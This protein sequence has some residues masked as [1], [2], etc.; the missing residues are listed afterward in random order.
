MRSADLI[1]QVLH[2]EKY[3]FD[4]LY[5]TAVNQFTPR[6]VLHKLSTHPHARIREHVAF[7]PKTDADT[8]RALHKDEHWAVR[9]GVA[10]HPNTPLDIL[11]ILKNDEDA[12]VR[13]H[14]A[15]GD[16]TPPDILRHLHADKV[17]AVR[18]AVAIHTDTPE[19]VLHTLRSGADKM[20]AR[21]AGLNLER[22][23]LIKLRQLKESHTVA[24]GDCFRWAFHRLHALEAQGI[25]A[26]MH[27]GTLKHPWT[28][29]RF[30][31]AW[32]EH[33]DG[34][35]EDWQMSNGVRQQV[36][37]DKFHSTWEPK[38]TRSYA[39]ITALKLGLRHK[40][41]GPWP[42]KKK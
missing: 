30:K 20:V 4:V 16:T 7:N 22:K 19:N 25:K 21:H 1:S 24:V 41:Y 5:K 28:G 34:K 39:S 3:S 40:H 27:H 17:A 26:R 10:Q 37:P 2:E 8:L 11:H 31:H 23:S 6:D 18:Q 36:T 42:R 9:S 29:K 15:L 12:H 13:E 33:P 32:V 35:I 38:V 14:V